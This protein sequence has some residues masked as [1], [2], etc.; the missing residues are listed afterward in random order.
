MYVCIVYVASMTYTTRGAAR[1]AYSVP[2][3]RVFIQKARLTVRATITPG[4]NHSIIYYN[5][6]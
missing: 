1:I 5:R 4:C 6:C 2:E 3:R